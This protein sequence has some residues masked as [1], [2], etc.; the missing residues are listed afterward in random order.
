MPEELQRL[1]SVP[2]AVYGSEGHM[3]DPPPGGSALYEHLGA[4]SGATMAGG[5]VTF[6][7]ID[8]GEF[9]VWYDEILFLHRAQGEFELEFEGK[10]HPMKEGD[11]AWVRA[12]TKVV[13][14]ARGGAATLFFAVSPADWAHRRPTQSTGA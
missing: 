9:K 7:D 3:P 13:Y 5:L 2:F 10:A 6:N 14:R 1:P 8:T 11:V 12:G 4:R